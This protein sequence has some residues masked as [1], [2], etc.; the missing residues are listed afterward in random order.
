MEDLAAILAAL[1]TGPKSAAETVASIPADRRALA[2]RSLHWLAKFDLI[3]L[4][5]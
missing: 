1:A 2:L 3:H 4:I 5:M